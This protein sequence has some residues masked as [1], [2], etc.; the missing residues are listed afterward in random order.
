M[1]IDDHEG[2]EDEAT[3][4]EAVER[5]TE[6]DRDQVRHVGEDR[7]AQG[8]GEEPDAEQHLAV[9][10]LGEERHQ[11]EHQD[12]AHLADRHESATADADHLVDGRGELV[13]SFAVGRGLDAADEVRGVHEVE[14]VDHADRHRDQEECEQGLDTDLAQRLG[15]GQLLLRTLGRRRVRQG[16]AVERHDQ[17]EHRTHLE[18]HGTP[19][20]ECRGGLL[21]TDTLRH[22]EAEQVL[23]DQDARGDPAEGAPEPDRTEVAIAVTDVRKGDRVGEGDGRGVDEA[24]DQGEHEERVEAVDLGQHP[25][26]DCADQVAHEE[27]LLG[28]EV[29]VGELTDHERTEDRAD[30][31][32][33]QTGPGLFEA[34]AAMPHQEGVQDRKPGSPDRVLQEHHE[35]ETGLGEGDE[36]LCGHV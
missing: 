3:E 31:T 18:R 15:P 9:E 28:G 6:E 11:P 14:L 12:L 22:R 36:N 35:G 5:D 20:I 19:G 1:F 30:R 7:H 17:T 21:R 16:Q 24:V 32:G 33:R 26:Q 27:E 25:D 8:V 10:D 4:A 13:R 2:D 34:E 29:P 23:P